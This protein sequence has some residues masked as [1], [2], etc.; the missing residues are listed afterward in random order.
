MFLHDQIITNTREA[1][2]SIKE[3][4]PK[5]LLEKNSF[6]T[7]IEK[8]IKEMPFFKE[9]DFE[10]NGLVYF[11][12]KESK[13]LEDIL[14]SERYCLLSGPPSIRKT[15]FSLSFGLYLKAQK[16]YSV[17]YHEVEKDEE[18]KIWK[19]ILENIKLYDENNILFIFDECHNSPDIV[20]KFVNKVI[21][22]MNNAKF[23][24]VS[25][26]VSE[27]VFA[28]QKFNYFKRLGEKQT[29]SDL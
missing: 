23:L 16:Q 29:W 28:D 14:E 13:D 2:E 11:D 8:R 22:S 1:I 26:K 6:F 17:F 4:N 15:T 21:A 27:D 20:G 7:T 10:K 12:E 3:Q 24:F 25:R 5:E 18:W 19:D 9:K